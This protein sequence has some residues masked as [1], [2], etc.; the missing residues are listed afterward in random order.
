MTGLATSQKSTAQ[1]RD[2]LLAQMYHPVLL[3]VNLMPCRAAASQQQALPSE[4]QR[5]ETL[6]PMTVLPGHE[7]QVR[8][9]TARL[10]AA[11]D[12]LG[13]QLADW[14]QGRPKYV[15]RSGPMLGTR[16][17]LRACGPQDRVGFHDTLGLEPSVADQLTAM[18][19]ASKASARLAMPLLPMVCDMDPVR[20]CAH[21][22]KQMAVNLPL[23]V[24][25]ETYAAVCMAEFFFGSPEVALVLVDST[26]LFQNMHAWDLTSP[27]LAQAQIASPALFKSLWQV[28]EA[29][30]VHGRGFAVSG[31]FADDPANVPFLAGLGCSQVFV[32]PAAHAAV[33]DVAQR[34]AS[35]GPEFGAALANHVK[36]CLAASLPA[37]GATLAINFLRGLG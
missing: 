16:T 19:A 20:R 30:K 9:Y 17:L 36:A 32:T 2:A 14:P 21:Y 8:V 35:K 18:G 3:S 23:G 10:A 22:L 13:L 11:K 12:P 28:S 24:V 27:N 29:A 6:F 31:L 26:D 15:D 34:I 33:S 37:E 4:I 25:L 5:S 1:A 7:E